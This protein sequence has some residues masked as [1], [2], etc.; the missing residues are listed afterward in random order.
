M[1]RNSWYVAGLSR[2]F[3]YKL[4]KKIVTALPIVM[5]RTQD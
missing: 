3:K 4:D 5:W 1:I 2:N